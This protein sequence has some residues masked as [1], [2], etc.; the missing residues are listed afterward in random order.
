VS[1]INFRDVDLEISMGNGQGGVFASLLKKWLVD[2]K[3]GNVQHEWG[4]VINEEE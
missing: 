3:Y 1:A 4:V 2:I